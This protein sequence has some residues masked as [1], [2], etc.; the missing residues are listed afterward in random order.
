MSNLY[1]RKPTTVSAMRF[2][3]GVLQAAEIRSWLYLWSD[4]TNW[5][6]ER[7]IESREAVFNGSEMLIPIIQIPEHLMV[8]T[9]TGN[10]KVSL[11]CWLIKDENGHLTVMNDEEFQN[12]F[13]EQVDFTS[14]LSD[15][16]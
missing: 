3:G 8:I 7:F 13:T 16:K 5:H 6:A 2:T 11:G 15:S 4:E 14:R 12:T 9:D 1:E 10:Y